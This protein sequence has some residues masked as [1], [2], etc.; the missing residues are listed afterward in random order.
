MLHHQHAHALIDAAV[1]V[2][3]CCSATMGRELE[4]PL[5]AETASTIASAPSVFN[6]YKFMS[7]NFTKM[8]MGPEVMA[9]FKPIGWHTA[10][11][12][13]A[14]DAAYSTAGT[15][16]DGMSGDTSYPYG[17]IKVLATVGEYLPSNGYMLVGVPDGMGAMLMDST[18]VRIIFQSESYGPITAGESHP[19]LVNPSNA[20]FTG[21][22]VMYVDYD[23][24][25]LSTFMDNPTSPAMPMVKNAG[26]MIESA[27]NLAGNLIGPRDRTT[28]CSA[29]PHYSNTDHR[30]CNL[31]WTTI[32][33]GREPE[34]ADWL[35][36]SLCSAHL[37]EKHQWGGAL[38][39]EDD[40]FI[41]NEEW[42]SFRT[43]SD[44]TGIP[45]HVI[46]IHTKTIHA[47]GVFTLG[48]FEKIVEFNCGHSAY[49]CFAPSGY[50]GNFDIDRNAEAARK[51]GMGLR[52]D[53]TPYVFTE[54]V[55]PSR[56]YVGVK[57]RNAQGQP[58]TDFLS[59]NGLAY[60]KVYGFA[61][62]VASTTGGRFQE[63]WHLNVATNGM[64]VPG[65]FYPIDW[66]WNGTVTSFMHDGSWAFQHSTSDGKKFWN[67]GGRSNPSAFDTRGSCKTEHNSPDPYGGP[68]VM[69]GSTCGYFGIYD[70]SGVTAFL[71]QAHAAGT[72]FPT[73]IP[74]TY[75]ALQG[76]RDIRSQIQ[77]G[78]KGMYA[79]GND[80]SY[81]PDS[82]SAVAAGVGGGKVTFEDIDGLEWIAAAGTTDGYVVI[83]EDGGN[84]LGERTFLTKV[85]SDGT[86]MTYY[87]IAISGGAANTRMQ[88]GVGVPAG[89]NPSA[90][91][92]EF[93]GVTD[94][95]GMLKKDANGNFIATAGV[96]AT[97]RTAERNTAINDKI[98]AFGLQAHNLNGGIIAAMSGDRGGQVYAYK[99]HLP[100][101]DA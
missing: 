57:G 26:S 96:G 59:R 47:T 56:V 8:T 99:P 52:P 97:K 68:R 7:S 98:I 77:L 89:T 30:G 35:M 32:M 94:L 78:G 64:Q 79:N 40:L 66:Q 43:G 67:Q 41:T 85:R 17:S 12:C 45:A 72:H 51:N 82:S 100:A 74:A 1:R 39:V 46:D 63:D 92:H 19:F 38:G 53:G 54:F 5:H 65:G 83:Q 70:L 20:S 49:V 22:H 27:Y 95:S 9:N 55:V 21:S 71:Q 34:R 6:A 73:S 88:A 42:T 81:M 28:A 69:Q 91:S 44:Y 75:T 101:V 36:Q 15:V 16:A 62:D 87:L 11:I 3:R 48:G 61:T 2:R 58:A 80:A 33:L 76:E 60:G 90:G 14:T 86:P 24:Q 29:N 50:N 18:T 4:S 13:E 25:Q 93:S 23:R 31:G 10:H 84:F 37:E